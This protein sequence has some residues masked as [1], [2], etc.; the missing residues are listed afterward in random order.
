MKPA[1]PWT[2]RL[3]AWWHEAMTGHRTHLRYTKGKY[4][5]M[6]CRSCHRTY[7]YSE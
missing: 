3:A 2:A 4:R 6:E 7:H 5:W 1:I